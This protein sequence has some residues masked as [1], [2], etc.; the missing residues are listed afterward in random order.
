VDIRPKILSMTK[1]EHFQKYQTW[2]VT[3]A[4]ISFFFINNTIIATSVIMEAERQGGELPFQWWQPFTWEYSSA[5]G[6][7][8]LIP[9]LIFLLKKFPIEWHNLKRTIP[10]YLAISIPFSVLHVGIMVGIRKMLY[11]AH[12][13][14]YKFGNITFELIYEYRKDFWAF[15]AYIAAVKGY[16]F[17]LSRLTGEANLIADGEDMPKSQPRDRLLVKKLGKEFIIKMEDVE[18][19]E[20]S[21]NYVNL[22]IKG[23]I[24]PTRATLSGLIDQIRSVKRIFVASSVPMQSIWIGLIPLRH[25]V[26]V[27]A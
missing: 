23:R 2:Y 6:T 10:L 17:A 20:A 26:V 27:I 12:S 18:W 9:G 3:G 16:Q 5:I 15:I 1:L 19:M 4:L 8:I 11:W 22:H 13:Q 7:L 21:G 14:S 24:Y 25:S